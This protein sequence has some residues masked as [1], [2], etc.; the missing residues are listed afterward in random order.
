MSSAQFDLVVRG[1]ELVMPGGV[2]RADIGVRGGRIAAIGDDA[3]GMVGARVV[4]AAGL[5]V[6]PG[7]V[8]V[9]VHFST[10]SH[11]VDTLRDSF[12]SAA[13]GGVTTA[14]GMIRGT[15]EMRPVQTLR[16]FRA[17]GERDAVVD[18]A[19]H[20]HLP[21]GNAAIEDVPA[22][23]A[24]GTTS[25]KIFLTYGPL[26]ASDE[27]L[28]RAMQA[29]AAA[30]GLLCVH[31]EDGGLIEALEAQQ[32]AAGRIGPA[33][34]LFTHPREAETLATT[35]VIQMARLAG[36]GIYVLHISTPEVAAQVQAA[37]DRGQAI[38]AETCPQY[39]TL[40]N[41]TVLE[42]GALAK[43][44]PPLREPEDV[45][46]LWGHLAAGR[47]H[48]VGSDHSPHS[49]ETKR[50]G[51][52]NIFDAWF[53]CAGTE[54]MLPVMYDE[55]VVR[56]GLP[57][58]LLARLLSE[59]PAKVF[60]LYPRKGAIEVGA[61]ADLVLFDP[62][63]TVAIRAADL[64]TESD[65]TLFEGR[66]VQGWPHMTIRRGEV[67]LEGGVLAARPGSGRFLQRAPGI[68]KE[69]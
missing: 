16:H 17:E 22:A 48:T 45:E 51:E 64:H 63:R 15:A 61:D 35:K 2:R 32:I 1:G 24:E 53:G 23:V 67:L 6:L 21:E 37:R 26:R 12:V 62:V 14:I 47:I 11:H 27:H 40:T 5:L 46:G 34:F 56:R 31:C 54:T 4:D 18:F 59:R 3:V 10:F 60:G 55:V 33:D 42:R 36:C 69:A 39:L 66:Q 44:A 29:V 38:W 13:H 20:L 49:R 19:F 8:D 43:I 65:Y 25:F 41:Q 68:A 7:V 52:R 30:G 50:P 58:T 28:F 9:H 57:V